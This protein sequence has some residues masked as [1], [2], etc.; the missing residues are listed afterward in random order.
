MRF[1]PISW[2]TT[3]RLPPI[4][5]IQYYLVGHKWYRVDTMRY[6]CGLVESFWLCLRCSS[7]RDVELTHALY[8]SQTSQQLT[9]HPCLSMPSQSPA[10]PT[11]GE[12]T[13]TTTPTQPMT[14]QATGESKRAFSGKLPFRT[15]SE[16]HEQIYHAAVQAGMSINAW[17]AKALQEAAQKTLTNSASTEVISPAINQLMQHDPQ[18]F[19]QLIDQVQPHLKQQTANDAVIWLSY[20]QKLIQDFDRLQAN[21]AMPRIE[22]SAQL[23]QTIMPEL[24]E[25]KDSPPDQLFLTLLARMFDAFAQQ[26]E[27]DKKLDTRILT[28][29]MEDLNQLKNQLK[30]MDIPRLFELLLHVSQPIESQTER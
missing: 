30:N 12:S 22:F 10:S 7:D 5:Q 18:R 29:L 11:S 27:S 4:P 6:H 17:M 20:V 14:H 23:K 25:H 13:A 26:S 1:Q 9:L 2:L 21:L 19:I 28:S 8:T 16:D 24:L 15:T 3:A